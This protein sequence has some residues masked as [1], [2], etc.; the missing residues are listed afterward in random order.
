MKKEIK[1]SLYLP[2][3]DH[4]VEIWKNLRPEIGEPAYFARYTYQDEGTWYYVSDP[5]GYCELS[6]PVSKEILFLCCDQAGREYYQY[7]NADPNLLPKFETVVKKEWE[8]AKKKLEVMAEPDHK[9]DFWLSLV[10][11]TGDRFKQWLL[12]F[13]DPERYGKEIEA[14]YGY[15]EN[16]LYSCREEISSETVTY[17]APVNLK[18]RSGFPKMTLCRKGSCEPIPGTVFTYL[19]T[20]Y[21]FSRVSCRHKVCGVTWIEYHCTKEKPEWNEMYHRTES[22]GLFGYDFNSVIE[23][24]MYDKRTAVSLVI[25]ALRLSMPSDSGYYLITEKRGYQTLERYTERYLAEHMMQG[26]YRKT[27][28][29]NLTVSLVNACKV[30]GTNQWIRR[31]NEVI[32]IVNKVNTE[33]LKKLYPDIPE[34][35]WLRAL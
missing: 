25:D 12:S 28:I 6:H 14:M 32:C 9:Q 2:E 24:P 15:D 26:N 35:E 34:W 20:R 1:V 5:L 19:G 23:G 10:G 29:G 11:L 18:E 7:S 30:F 3:N 16:W 13:K 8:K 33:T 4:Y 17:A 21:C 31:G 22:Y 27:V